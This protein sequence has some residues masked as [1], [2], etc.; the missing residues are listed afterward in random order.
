[1]G[2][3]TGFFFKPLKIFK[4]PIIFGAFLVGFGVKN[5]YLCKNQSYDP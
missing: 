1:M 5:Y 3:V 4:N 2:K